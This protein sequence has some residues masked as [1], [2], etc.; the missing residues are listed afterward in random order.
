M[1]LIFIGCKNEVEPNYDYS[2]ILF[3][4]DGGGNKEFYIRTNSAHEIIMQVT[5]YNFRDTN[6]TTSVFVEDEG[7]LSNLITRVL[8]NRVTLK[9]DFKQS[10]LETGTWAYIYVADDDNNKTEITNTALRDSLMILETLIENA[11]K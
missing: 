7:K 5:Q 9:G 3:K 6:Y 1:S 4:R 8:N 2:K 10:E 11:R